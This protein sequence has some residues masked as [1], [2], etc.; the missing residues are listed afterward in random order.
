MQEFWENILNMIYPRHCPICHEILRDQKKLACPDCFRKLHPLMGARCK[1]CGKPVEKEAE[2]CLDCGKYKRYFEE[3]RGAFLYDSM[4]KNS[5]MRYKYF[6]CREYADFYA[7]VLYKVAERDIRRW[8][9]D[10]IL[11]VPMHP[12]KERI[13]G[14]NQSR[15]L[16]EGIS[17]YSGILAD[18]TIVKKTQKT[19]SQKKLRAEERRRNLKD[20]FLVTA[21]LDGK[22]ILVID[23]VFTTGSTM[24]AMA[25]KLKKHGAEKVF[26]LT[27]CMGFR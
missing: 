20:A 8:K 16:A 5:L 23:D 27:I 3:G 7:Y 26:F 9:P 21:S 4:W 15:L 19:K 18:F 13:R 10:L 1:K 25:V 22:R 12:T 14:F 24:D 17:R 6:G 11:A 2:Y